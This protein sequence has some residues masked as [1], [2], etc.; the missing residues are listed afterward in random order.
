[1]TVSRVPARRNVHGEAGPGA[2]SGRG[3]RGSC[4]GQG[5][6]EWA[7]RA[8]HNRRPGKALTPFAFISSQGIVPARTSET[9][10]PRQST[11][12][13]R[14]KG[15]SRLG[16]GEK[17]RE[18][19]EG[20]GRGEEEEEQGEGGGS[21]EGGPNMSFSSLSPPLSPGIQAKGQGGGRTI[22]QFLHRAHPHQ[23]CHFLLGARNPPADAHL[24]PRSS[25]R[26][27]HWLARSQ[28][29]PPKAAAPGYAYSVGFWLT[30]Q[31]C[32]CRRQRTEPN[33]MCAAA[34]KLNQGLSCCT[35]H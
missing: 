16:R 7:P 34:C 31:P 32:L 21:K 25:S 5:T 10:D 6:G 15:A 33:H 22:A 28:P 18:R 29:C 1:M 27:G 26:V 4:A 11:W 2:C 20:R 19:G 8:L 3:H 12:P 35:A 9:Q 24:E 14:S 23:R 30:L 17:R 13:C